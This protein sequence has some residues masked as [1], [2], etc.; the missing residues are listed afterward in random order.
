MARHDNEVARGDRGL[1]DEA[2][3][4]PAPRDA[5]QLTPM[6]ELKH[7]DVARGDPDIRGWR[8]F[9]ST[10]RELGRVE[11][12]L[13]DAEAGE[14]VMLDVDL[15]RDDRHTLAPIRAAWIDREH[16]RVIIDS[17]EL[18][19]DEGVPS[20]ARR[21]ALSDADVRQFGDRYDRAY[22]ARAHEGERDYSVRHDVDDLR[23][24]R[25]RAADTEVVRERAV[26][27][28]REARASRIIGAE[29]I[30]VERETR[31]A[32]GEERRRAQSVSSAPADRRAL[33]YPAS[34]T[35]GA[36]PPPQGGRVI[37][38]VV[39]R[40]REVGPDEEVGPAR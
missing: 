5:R 20:L 18:E 17:R 1:R 21:G 10:G 13:V 12:L 29:P 7:F 36:T 3:V 8:V 25:R 24:G 30:V 27:D 33:H 6:R 28:E 4:G 19:T 26:D 9:T 22:G 39:V 31:D 38:E 14:V 35:P 2:N 34:T 23:F 16:E 40:R 15:R 32:A 37:E 11:D